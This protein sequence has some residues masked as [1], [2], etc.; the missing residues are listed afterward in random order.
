[1]QA[2]FFW[3]RTSYFSSKLTCAPGSAVFWA[4]HVL[5]GPAHPPL[6]AAPVRLPRHRRPPHRVST[7]RHVRLQVHVK[8]CQAGILMLKK[9]SLSKKKNRRFIEATVY[10]LSI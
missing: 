6:L 9:H 7:Q 2:V 3:L 1:M 4:G 8:Y 10:Q 5:V